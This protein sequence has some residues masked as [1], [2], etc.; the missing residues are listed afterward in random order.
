MA[1]TR[2]MS[3]CA[4][5]QILNAG[6]W[7]LMFIGSAPRIA[8][9]PECISPQIA[10]QCAR[11]RMSAGSSWALG[12]ISLRY[13]PMASVSQ[14]FTPLCCSEGTSIEADSSSISAF[15]AGSSGEMTFSVNS[16]PARRAISQPR[17]AQ[18]P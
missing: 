14:T 13:S 7:A 5:D 3:A 2:S 16:S 18:A 9:K 12:L 4:R 10:R 8:L 15:M 1:S 11:A 6:K 17:R